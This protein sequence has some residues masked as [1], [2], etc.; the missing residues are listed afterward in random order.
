MDE[1]RVMLAELEHGSD[2]VDELEQRLDEEY[3]TVRSTITE[4][5]DV[6]NL[7]MDWYD[8]FVFS[9]DDARDVTY[10]GELLDGKH[11]VLEGVTPLRQP[12]H[13]DES[14]N[15]A[16]RLDDVLAS[17]RR[18]EWQQYDGIGDE[19]AALLDDQRPVDVDEDYVEEAVTEAY[20]EV[21][22]MLVEGIEF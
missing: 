2:Q 12:D 3:S 11:V 8:A 18:D 17:V 5:D 22:G 13:I 1:Y 10:D 4:L 9:M 14:Y 6:A 20:S 15:T 19:L 16:D 7:V 21:G